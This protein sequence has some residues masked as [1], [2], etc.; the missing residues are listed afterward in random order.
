MSATATPERVE[1]LRQRLDAVEQRVLRACQTAGRRRG[2]VTLVVVTKTFPAS[3]V[4]A[5]AGMGVRDV[6]ESRDQEAAPKAAE[7]EDL[8]LRWHFVGRL[9]TN[10]AAS[11]AR[12]ASWVHSVDRSR[13]VTALD[14]GASRVGRV[15]DCLV[16]VDLSERP[17]GEP[18]GA[19]GRGGT[20]PADVA[21]LADEVAAA[22]WL[23]LAGVMGVAPLG[24][25][26]RAAF[27]RLVEVSCRLRER[28]PG[29]VAVSAGMSGDLEEAVGAGAT[30]L[31]VG[32][33]VLGSRPPLQ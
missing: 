3:D 11:V 10:K 9:Q 4:R 24:G 25:D 7:C 32:S 23:R 13:V 15:L 1:E 26:A 29:A 2:D 31:R 14:R 8:G 27:G 5:L 22:E 16:Q 19:G 20:A 28:H 33:A 12:Y 30:H 18:D 6:A 17:T 21:R